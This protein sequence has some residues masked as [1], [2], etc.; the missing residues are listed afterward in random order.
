MDWII[1]GA[2]NQGKYYKIFII[3]GG[4]ELRRSFVCSNFSDA[5]N[6]SFVCTKIFDC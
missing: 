5:I 4:L 3:K 2:A 1:S 6:Y